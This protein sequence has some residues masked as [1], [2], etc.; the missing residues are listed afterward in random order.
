MSF[1]LPVVDVN[2]HVFPWP[3]RHLPA[4]SPRQLAREL[5]AQTVR[6]AWVGSFES[7]LH[8]DI[9]GVN[10]R[11][12]D[13]CRDHGSQAPT[14]EQ[15]VWLPF[16]TV[17]PGLPDWR[18][19]LRRC[20]E[21]Y[22]MKGIRLYPNYHQYRLDSRPA[23]E[24]LTECARRGL[25]VQIVLSLEDTRTQH[26]LVR[27]SPVDPQSLMPAVQRLPR[28]PIVLL[29]SFRE[30]PTGKLESLCRA[31]RVYVELAT[32]ERAAGLERLLTTIPADRICYGS[33]VPLYYPSAA[34][35]KLN[36]AQIGQLQRKQIASENA[37]SLLRTGRNGK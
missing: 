18:E 25:I 29:N 34:R 2:V 24:L 33:N 15:T 37:E 23:R 12:T 30:T 8:R 3:F 27:V 16:G 14:K 4:S 19:D 11:L 28:L 13:V 10:R 17:H 36:S 1:A 31:G 7:V 6:T 22:R 21:Q 26:P 9:D 32:L 20:H 35:L 5:R